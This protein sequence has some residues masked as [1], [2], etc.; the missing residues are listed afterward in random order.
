MRF[1]MLRTGSRILS[2][3]HILPIAV[4]AVFAL[5]MLQ[6]IALPKAQAQT[7]T[8]DGQYLREGR[9]TRESRPAREGRA[10]QSDLPTVVLGDLP[11]EAQSTYQRIL[12]GGPFPYDKDSTVFGN[13]ER[14]LPAQGRGYYREYT[15]RTPWVKHR[16]ARR[17]VC[18]GQRPMTPDACFYTDD[19]YSSFRRILTPNTP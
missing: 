8:R 19:H 18:G 13:R 3:F 11:T 5:L 16:G 15:V 7:Y 2:R 12:V 10:A 9:E 1:S 14:I 6:I 4:L 17:I